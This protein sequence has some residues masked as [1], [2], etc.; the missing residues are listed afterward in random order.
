MN[1]FGGWASVPYGSYAL[2]VGSYE[3]VCENCFEKSVFDVLKTKYY[4][5]Y[6]DFFI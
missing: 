1:N 6:F 5:V 4:K 3:C 2:A